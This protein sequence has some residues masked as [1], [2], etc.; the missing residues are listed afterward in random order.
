MR[1][2]AYHGTVADLKLDR[3]QFGPLT[4][5]VQGVCVLSGVISFVKPEAAEDFLITIAKMVPL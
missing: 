5:A 1:S 4:Y 3:T 2:T